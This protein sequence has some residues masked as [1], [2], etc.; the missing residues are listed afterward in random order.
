M[1]GTLK[2]HSSCFT[3]APISFPFLV[4][5]FIF[6]VVNL[7]YSVKRCTVPSTVPGTLVH[8]VNVYCASWPWEVLGTMLSPDKVHVPEQLRV[9]VEGADTKDEMK[10]NA[11][12]IPGGLLNRV[13][14][15]VGASLRRDLGDI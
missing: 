14:L 11:F 2:G 4:S 12:I 1:R 9:R 10:G 3:L 7:M 5:H 13:G 15:G 8:V 6:N